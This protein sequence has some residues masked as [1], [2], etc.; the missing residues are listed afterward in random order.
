MAGGLPAISGVELAKL[1]EKD[2]WKRGRTCPH[3]DAYSKEYPSGPR[4]TTIP[5]RTK[6]LTPGTLSAI[7]GSKQTGIGRAGLLAL[8]KKHKKKK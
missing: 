5:R 7:L 1:L 8:I 3:G 2:G 6:S 4:V